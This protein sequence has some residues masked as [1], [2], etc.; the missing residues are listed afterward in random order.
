MPGQTERRWIALHH[1]SQN[2]FPIWRF[3][4]SFS[5]S[6]YHRAAW[7]NVLINYAFLFQQSPAESI[8]TL[9]LLCFP[10]SFIWIGCFSVLFSFAFFIW[11]AHFNPRWDL[12][13]LHRIFHRNAIMKALHGA[14]TWA[15]S[16]LH[17]H[18]F[19]C[20]HFLSLAL[21]QHKILSTVVDIDAVDWD[22][23]EY[24]LR[25][26]VCV[27]FGFSHSSATFYKSQQLTAAKAE[28]P[29]TF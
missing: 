14:T 25:F 1:R 13:L 27:G 9:A 17:L 10:P 5:I 23:N 20:L 2:H 22:V 15:V 7:L 26:C 11:W 21:S 8:L 24:F 3:P 16:S 4:A 29:A 19:S 12:M 6:W 18:C 28:L